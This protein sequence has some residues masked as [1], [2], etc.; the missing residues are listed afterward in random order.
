MSSDSKTKRGFGR[1]SIY[2]AIAI[3]V[4]VVAAIATWRLYPIVQKPHSSS[5]AYVNLPPMNLTLVGAN[6]TQK[7]L[8]ASDIAQLTPFTSL[9]GFETSVGSIQGVGN[10]TGV[11]LTTLCNLVGG[12]GTNDSVQITASDGYSMVFSYNQ[13][14]GNGFVTY[15]QTTGLEVS[16]EGSLTLVLAYHE[17]GKNLTYDNGAPLRL[18][19]LGNKGL[20][21]D[22]HYWVKWVEQI[23]IL[24]AIVE[25][26][27]MLKDVSEVNSTRTFEYNVTRSYF[28]AGE[29]PNCH[30][31]NWTDSSGNVWTGIPL[32]LLAASVEDWNFSM[33]FNASLAESNAYEVVVISQSGGNCTFTSSFVANSGSG[34]IVA[35]KLNGA[36][37]P[38]RY[39]PLRL[40]GSAVPS[41]DMVVNITEIEL[42]FLGS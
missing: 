8:H 25:W 21:T 3:I 41:D 35:N 29:A 39:W 27:L 16:N 14:N 26:T 23:Q 9:G 11:P 2:A 33:S 36:V 42:V 13:T 18:V 31:A 6:G 28:E 32:W 19:I 40:V 30:A 17:N 4:I 1:K 34:M 37:L 12:I 10:Y 20:L 7:V 15:N 22:G 38:A 5:V 24:P